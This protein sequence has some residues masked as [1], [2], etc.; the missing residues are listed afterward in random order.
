MAL[1]ALRYFGGS[2]LKDKIAQPGSD[3]N[4]TQFLHLYMA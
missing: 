3:T 1:M 4:V 2:E